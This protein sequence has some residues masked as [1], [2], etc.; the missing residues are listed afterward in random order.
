MTN[1]QILDFKFW[2]MELK[3]QNSKFKKVSEQANLNAR[4]NLKS[5]HRKLNYKPLTSGMG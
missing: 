5:K 3:I 1:D 4:I 2:I